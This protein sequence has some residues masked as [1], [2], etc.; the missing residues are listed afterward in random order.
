M[1]GHLRGYMGSK[2]AA[3]ARP[4]RPWLTRDQILVTLRRI[5]RQKR[6]PYE[7]P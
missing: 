5:G 4:F 6:R 3:V 2:P 7:H 1:P